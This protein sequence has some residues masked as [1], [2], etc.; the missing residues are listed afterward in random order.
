[1]EPLV[2]QRQ[3]ST[4]ETWRHYMREDIPPLFG[5]TFSPAIW[6]QGFIV[7]DGHAFLL[8][9]LEK[10]SLNKDHRYDDRFLSDDRFQWQSQNKTRQDSKHGRL[11]RDH[12]A[13]GVDVHLFVRKHKVLDG[14]AAPFVYC[15]PVKFE[16]WDGEK[17]ISVTWRLDN[18]VPTAIQ[19]ML[20]V[21]TA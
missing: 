3:H 14:K 9:T 11:I 18:A 2:L 15:G 12:D 5:L 6:N 4:A 17:P 1:M 10:G 19:R 21:P 16:S 8:V 20:E 13:A 7:A